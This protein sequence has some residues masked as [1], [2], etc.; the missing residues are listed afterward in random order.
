MNLSQSESTL[1]F[2]LL[3][4]KEQTI[5]TEIRKN[6]RKI[7]ILMEENFKHEEIVNEIVALQIRMNM[8]VF[9]D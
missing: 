9:H 3:E 5:R 8:T 7:E 4:E 6:E 2:S 1:M